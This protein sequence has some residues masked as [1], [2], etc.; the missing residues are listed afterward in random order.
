L[1]FV[2]AIIDTQSDGMV[3]TVA[4]DLSDQVA[5]AVGKGLQ[6]D[7]SDDKVRHKIGRAHV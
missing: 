4:D 1:A 7:I 2:N 6:G 5:D 3:K